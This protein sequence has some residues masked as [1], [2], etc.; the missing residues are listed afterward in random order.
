MA[1]FVTVGKVDEIV[2]GQA[3]AFEVGGKS[4]AVA[5]VDGELLAF[6]DICTHAK[7]NLSDGGEI[8]GAVIECECHGSRFDM[9]TG[10]VQQGPAST[11]LQVFEVLAA[12]RISVFQTLSR[13]VCTTQHASASVLVG[14]QFME[15]VPARSHTV[16][17]GFPD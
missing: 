2:E 10:G 17:L 6:G 12:G 11:P 1:D 9:K 3:K 16:S 7:C 15:I 5:R 14:V 4:V 13:R 8:V